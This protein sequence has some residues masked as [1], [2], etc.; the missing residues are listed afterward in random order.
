MMKE[1]YCS[2]MHGDPYPPC[3]NPNW[4]CEDCKNKKMRERRIKL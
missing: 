3:W 1:D 2:A 4:H